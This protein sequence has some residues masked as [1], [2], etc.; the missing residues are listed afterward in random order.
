MSGNDLRFYRSFNKLLTVFPVGNARVS[1]Q[2]RSP[3]QKSRDPHESRPGNL[4]SR[5]QDLNLRPPGYEH[6][7]VGNRKE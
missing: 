5:G 3:K 1:R 7:G 6:L 2:A 4:W